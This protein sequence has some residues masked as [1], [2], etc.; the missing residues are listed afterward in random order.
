MSGLVNCDAQRTLPQWSHYQ[1]RDRLGSSPVLLGHTPDI[2]KGR[3]SEK[4]SLQTLPSSLGLQLLPFFQQLQTEPRAHTT[5]TRRLARAGLS[6]VIDSVVSA[7]AVVK[8]VRES[9]LLLSLLKNV[10]R[11]CL[12]VNTNAGKILKIPKLPKP[13][14]FRLLFFART[15]K[16]STLTIDLVGDNRQRPFE[17]CKEPGHDSLP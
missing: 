1:S 8:G 13:R 11:L 16:G 14:P 10:N 5:G 9:H 17:P 15:K 6:A 12:R 4:A 2:R 3:F 7:F